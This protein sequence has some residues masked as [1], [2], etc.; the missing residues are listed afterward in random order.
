MI[1]IN[2]LQDLS[3]EQLYQLIVMA[4]LIYFLFD[5]FYYS[6][7]LKETVTNK[8]KGLCCS[9]CPDLLGNFN[10]SLGVNRT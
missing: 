6:E 1:I 10:F 8:T 4:V 5:S 7:W 9:P 3:K 2:A